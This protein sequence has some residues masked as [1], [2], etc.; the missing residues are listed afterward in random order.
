MIRKSDETQEYR[1]E[2][3]NGR[4]HLIDSYPWHPENEL[5]IVT[6]GC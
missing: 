2:I 5:D 4:F 6:I 1:V 3:Y